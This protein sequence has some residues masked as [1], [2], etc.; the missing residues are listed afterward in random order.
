MTGVGQ[1]YPYQ[2]R[3]ATEPWPTLLDVPTGLGKTAGVTLAW[4]YKRLHRDKDTPRR[5]LWCLP[6]RVLVEQTRDN[7]LTWLRRA[8]PLF[9][10]RGLTVPTCHV[11]MG[12]EVD[13]AWVER[14]EDPAIIIGT[15]DMLLSRALMRGYGVSRYRWPMDFA[16]VHHDALWVFDEV[17]L[18]GAG[19]ATSA[20]L[21]AFRRLP[22]MRSQPSARS[23][24]LSATLRSEWLCT[25]DFREHVHNLPVLRLSDDELRVEPVRRRRE[26]RKT[27]QRAEITLNGA[28][29]DDTVAYVTALAG[30]VLEEH[31]GDGPT[32]VILNT[33]ERAQSVMAHLQKLQAERGGSTELLLVHGRFRPAEREAIN[34]RIK[35]LKPDDDI[36]IVATQAIEAGVDVTSRRL[37]TELAPWAS[38][39]QRFGRC[40]RGGEYNDTPTGALT[41]WLD[42]Q[43]EHDQDLAQ[44]YDA[45]QLMSSRA[46]LATLSSV[47]PAD[48]PPVDEGPAF[49][50]VLRKKDFME[51]FNTEPDLSGHDIDIS[52]YVRDAGQ[53]HIQVFWREFED[54]PGDQPGPDR[55]EL[56]PVSIGQLQEHIG[57][58]EDKAYLWDTLSERWKPVRSTQI[59]PGQVI[60]LRASDGGYDR[61]LGFVPGLRA[62]RSPIAVLGPRPW[63][64][65][66]LQREPSVETPE[67][68][69]EDRYTHA[70]DFVTLAQHSLAV[71]DEAVRLCEALGETAAHTAVGTAALW[72]DVGKAH[73]AAQTAYSDFFDK[74][75]APMPRDQLWAK[76]PGTG[77]LR[78]RIERDGKEQSRRYF[79]HE[80]ASVLA[81][82]EHGQR[83]ETYDLIAYLIAAHHGKIRLGI[84]ALPGEGTPPDLRRFAR[85]IWEGD[86]LPPVALNGV[87]LPETVLR[88]DVM[89]LGEGAMGPSWMARTR[90]LLR[91]LGPF[92]LAW[93]ETLVRV[94]DWRASAAARQRGDNAV[95][96]TA[97]ARA[98]HDVAVGEASG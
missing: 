97:T 33:V 16:L 69:G 85:G 88:L 87:S 11:L 78:Y 12:G 39:V 77:K 58:E 70:D 86:T 24:W 65:K 60:L 48:L 4:L 5:L 42:I 22:S 75:R 27:L 41:Y 67:G 63:S 38:M 83:D 82:L 8:S 59:R 80:L 61:T 40:N 57:Q 74:A 84:R 55:A 62:E 94:A 9:V 68:Y 50:H 29:R 53:P 32:L 46:K 91:E 51:L 15:Q 66:G 72:H 26:A 52:H 10:Q 21:E 1:P 28:K 6:M 76:V 35:A 30:R 45:D 92:R 34:S 44:P 98:A 89:E 81:W 14:P 13:E 20:Q 73:E 25:V 49:T 43:V 37:F 23:L 18:M 2:E 95:R 19:L 3:L 79:R 7:V 64:D 93:L 47:A 96:D 17:Q 71:R 36:I 54:V 56:C 90:R 31:R